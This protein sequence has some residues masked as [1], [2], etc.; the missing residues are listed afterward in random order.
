MGQQ[1]VERRNIIKQTLSNQ[2]LGH[3]Q[4]ISSSNNNQ[5]DE[6]KMAH[7]NRMK[8]S[9]ILNNNE[10][11]SDGNEINESEIKQTKENQNIICNEQ[12]ISSNDN[13]QNE[14]NP[15]LEEDHAS[16]TLDASFNANNE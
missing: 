7:L 8:T 12:I 4:I 9:S 6:N 15:Q 1:F 13:N 10:L 16:N 5:N 11:I 2:S 14:E 3:Q